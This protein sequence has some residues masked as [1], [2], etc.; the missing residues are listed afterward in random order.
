MFWVSINKVKLINISYRR[1]IFEN[2]TKFKSV[3][4]TCKVYALQEKI[5][6][7]TLT[8]YI[9]LTPLYQV[10]ISVKASSCHLVILLVLWHDKIYSESQWVHLLWK[11]SVCLKIWQGELILQWSSTQIISLLVHV[12]T[13]VPIMIHTWWLVSIWCSGWRWFMIWILHANIYLDSRIYMPI[14]FPESWFQD[15]YPEQFIFC[16]SILTCGLS[17]DKA[18]LTL[19]SFL[20]PHMTPKNSQVFSLQL[21]QC[22]G[23]KPDKAVQY[24]RSRAFADST[25]SS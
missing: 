19:T 22:H 25:K 14:V 17:Y 18:T 24:Y 23:S 15:Y 12:S 20:A 8:I 11:Y 10:C 1:H 3:R 2:I 9:K 5:K 6:N 13:K 16:S 21:S 7:N 4:I